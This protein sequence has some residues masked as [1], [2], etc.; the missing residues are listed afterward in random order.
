MTTPT[1]RE[2]VYALPAFTTQSGAT[3]VP[4]LE[5]YSNIHASWFAS[6]KFFADRLYRVIGIK[7]VAGVVACAK[8]FFM[9][10]ARTRSTR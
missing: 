8:G 3:P 6:Q 10:H 4:G 5:A 2:G 7:D 1:M 9:R